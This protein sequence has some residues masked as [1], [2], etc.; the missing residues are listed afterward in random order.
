MNS[1]VRVR[2]LGMY[3]GITCGIVVKVWSC[4]VYRATMRGLGH[5]KT[6]V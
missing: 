3:A 1:L 2:D 6:E 5:R 4:C